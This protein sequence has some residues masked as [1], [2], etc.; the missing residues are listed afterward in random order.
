MADAAADGELESTGAFTTT[1][2]EVVEKIG[3]C[4]LERPT[5]WVLLL[6]QLANAW[7]AERISFTFPAE[8]IRVELR[9]VGDRREWLGDCV[10]ELQS[11]TVSKDPDTSLVQKALW[12]ALAHT[13]GSMVLVSSGAKKN[14]RATAVRLG[15]DSS[16]WGGASL[17]PNGFVIQLSPA[18][19]SKFLAEFCPQMLKD[20]DTYSCSDKTLV[21]CG[22]EVAAFVPIS[23]RGQSKKAQESDEGGLHLGVWAFATDEEPGIP[24]GRSFAKLDAQGLKKRE[25]TFGTFRTGLVTEDSQNKSQARSVVVFT[26]HLYDVPSRIVWLDRGVEVAHHALTWPAQR[27]AVTVYRELPKDV[28]WDISHRAFQWKKGLKNHL[29]SGMKDV[30]TA[31]QLMVGEYNRYSPGIEGSTLGCWTLLALC[32]VGF[33]GVVAPVM[34]SQLALAFGVVLALGLMRAEYKYRYRKRYAIGHSLKALAEILDNK[35]DKILFKT[36]RMFPNGDPYD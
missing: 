11:G 25:L 26:Y 16:Q 22:R 1:G 3:Q 5:S 23:P 21:T 33:A 13:K 32:S 12:S 6:V 24:L 18:D 7:Q 4:L 34:G 28:T 36:E 8:S 35:K 10:A 29:K 19:P 15:L 2:S 20:L 14:E 9:G 17:E 31:F 30:D 27:L